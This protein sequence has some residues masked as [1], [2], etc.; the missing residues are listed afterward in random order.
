MV[1][2]LINGLAEVG[3][4]KVLIRNIHGRGPHGLSTFCMFEKNRLGLERWLRG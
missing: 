3:S 2:S 1:L 4:N